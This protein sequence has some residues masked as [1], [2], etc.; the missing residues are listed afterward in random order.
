[1]TLRLHLHSV[2]V[3]TTKMAVC[4]LWCRLRCVSVAGA[5]GMGPGS[6]SQQNAFMAAEG[7]ATVVQ[8]LDASFGEMVGRPPGRCFLLG[9][10][11]PASAP[12]HC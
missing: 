5:S 2:K 8:G 12:G 4:P 9:L 7:L 3:M 10:L 11:Q 1:M 6:G